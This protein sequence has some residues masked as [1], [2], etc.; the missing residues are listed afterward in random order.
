M[1]VTRATLFLARMWSTTAP[2]SRTTRY[3]R[4]TGLFAAGGSSIAFSRVEKP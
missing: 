1:S 3:E 2:M 4:E